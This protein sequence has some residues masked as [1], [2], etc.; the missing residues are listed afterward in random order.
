MSRNIIQYPVTKEEKLA[1]LRRAY[2]LLVADIGDAIGGIEPYVLQLV[3]ED[4][5]RMPECSSS[6]GLPRGYPWHEGRARAPS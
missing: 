5:T 4:I 1:V 6:E 3:I 2:D